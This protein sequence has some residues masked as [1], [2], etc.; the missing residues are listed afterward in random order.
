MVIYDFYSASLVFW[1]A[2]DKGRLKWDFSGGAAAFDVLL[3]VT[4]S[5]GL[6]T[7]GDITGYR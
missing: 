7:L 2:K 6:H 5:M 4:H 3:Q 1:V